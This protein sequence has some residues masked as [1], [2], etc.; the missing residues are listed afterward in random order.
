M[1]A[2]TIVGGGHGAGKTTY[3]RRLLAERGGHYLTN[4]VIRREHP[5][6]IE[7][8][9]VHRILRE[10]AEAHLARGE[11][12]LFEHIMSGRFAGRLIEMARRSRFSVELIYLDVGDVERAVSRIETRVAEGGHDVEREHVADRLRESRINFWNDYRA[13][14]DR[15]RLLDT[16]GGTPI[17]FARSGVGSDEILD[18]NL[19]AIFRNRLAG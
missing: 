17:E 19:F 2:L 12:F 9:D 14:A 11:P 10:R 3:C 5:D 6:G 18:A 16:S 15:W 7:R 13:R 8:N 4:E 1:T